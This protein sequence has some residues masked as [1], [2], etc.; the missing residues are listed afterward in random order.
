M[1]VKSL[2]DN[3]K[4][5][6]KILII[7]LIAFFVYWPGIPLAALSCQQLTDDEICF[8]IAS[9][10]ITNPYNDDIWDDDSWSGNWIR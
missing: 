3:M 7:V 5:R 10:R 9:L 4:T 2:G 1:N 8:D 6:Y